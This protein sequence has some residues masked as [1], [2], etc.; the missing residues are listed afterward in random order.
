M[1]NTIPP[2]QLLLV[3]I[4][5]LISFGV[6]IFSINEIINMA[7]NESPTLVRA[8][9]SIEYEGRIS[10]ISSTPEKLVYDSLES[11]LPT[12]LRNSGAIQSKF[13]ISPDIKKLPLDEQNNLIRL[14]LLQWQIEQLNNKITT[15]FNQKNE[16]LIFQ[17]W[18]WIFS[19]I[20]WLFS[21][22]AKK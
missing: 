22:A 20:I 9:R 5:L 10:E 11:K 8:S 2:K 21:I 16:S 1:E 15:S 14:A 18:F 19:S 13:K 17:I 6:I 4:A 3:L 7:T 12:D